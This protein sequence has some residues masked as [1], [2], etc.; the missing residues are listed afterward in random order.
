MPK[1]KTKKK[2]KT[3]IVLHVD[4]EEQLFTVGVVQTFGGAMKISV[5]V[6]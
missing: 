2:M 5:E 3:E 1:K 6:P 4:K